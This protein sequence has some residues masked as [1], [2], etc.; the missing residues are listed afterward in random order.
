METPLK[1]VKLTMPTEADDILSPEDELQGRLRSFKLGARGKNPG[2]SRHRTIRRSVRTAAKQRRIAQETIYKAIAQNAYDWYQNDKRKP[3]RHSI[4]AGSSESGILRRLARSDPNRAALYNR[5]AAK[6]IYKTNN[7]E[8][9]RDWDQIDLHGL[10][11]R[12][13]VNS[14][15]H[16]LRQLR[17]DP[18]TRDHEYLT[19]IVGRG[20]HSQNGPVLGPAIKKLLE[21]HGYEYWG[22]ND[23]GLIIIKL[24]RGGRH[25]WPGGNT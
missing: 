19:V 8:R 16:T 10:F 18:A 3:V 22:G 2:D 15:K 5:A 11:V 17:G 21:S 13:A 24:Q 12:E 20:I 6:L 14:I 4:D 1:Y 25:C 7:H 23:S 9:G